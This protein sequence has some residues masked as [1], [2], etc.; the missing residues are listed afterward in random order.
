[1]NQE[2]RH[3]NKPNDPDGLTDQ[4]FSGSK[5]PWEKS[6]TEVWNELEELIAKEDQSPVPVRRLLPQQA[7]ARTGCIAGSP[8]FCVLI[9]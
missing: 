5:I 2:N 4:Y 7:M 8:S 9:S 1:M 3:S 6:K